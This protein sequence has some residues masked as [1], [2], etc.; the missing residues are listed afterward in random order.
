VWSILGGFIIYL[1]IKL[2]LLGVGIGVGFLLHWLIPAIDVGI[3]VLFGVIATGCS[4]FF[5][6]LSTLPD[7]DLVEGMELEPMDRMIYRLGPPRDGA[8]DEPLSKQHLLYTHHSALSPRS[9]V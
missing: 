4:L 1:L 7:A 8:D 2:F 5:G 3:G 6:R 9:D